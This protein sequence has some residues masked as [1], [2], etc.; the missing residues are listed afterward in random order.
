MPMTTKLGW[1]VTYIKGFLSKKSLWYQ[2]V[3]LHQT[4]GVNE[5]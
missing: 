4:N 2:V 5:V 1:M 3:Y